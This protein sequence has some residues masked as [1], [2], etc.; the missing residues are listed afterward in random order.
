[1]IRGRRRLRQ[2]QVQIRQID[3]FKATADDASGFT[4]DGLEMLMVDAYTVHSDEVQAK[5]DGV[6]PPGGRESQSVVGRG[7]GYKDSPNGI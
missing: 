3:A 1:M 6:A 5:A 4:L 7:W 2:F